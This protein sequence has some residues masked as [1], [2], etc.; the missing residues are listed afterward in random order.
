MYTS[1]KERE[2]GR[3]GRKKRGEGERE[4]WKKEERE[5]EREGWKKEERGGREED[6]GH[7]FTYTFPSRVC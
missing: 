4:G 6:S 5:E 7:T 2:R 3:D 1:D